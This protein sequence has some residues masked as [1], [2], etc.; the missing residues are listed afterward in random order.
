MAGSFTISRVMPATPEQVYEAWL[1]TDEHSEMTG[2]SATCEPK[3]GGMFA[4][5]NGYIEG[6]NVELEPF[7]RIVQR[8]R[9][10]EFPVGAPDSLLEIVLE[11]LNGGTIITLNHREIPEGQSGSCKVGWFEHYFE[12]MAAHFRLIY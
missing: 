6:S 4:A 12:P 2:A 8:W 9:T 5:L 3:I 1:D 10:V 7:N 11:A